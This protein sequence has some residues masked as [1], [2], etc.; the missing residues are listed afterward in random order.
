MN[1]S[2]AWMPVEFAWVTTFLPVRSSGP[3]IDSASSVRTWMAV[4]ER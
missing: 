2:A 3:E 4:P 1:S